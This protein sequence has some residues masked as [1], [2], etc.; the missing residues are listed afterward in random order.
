MRL[1]KNRVICSYTLDS[2]IKAAFPHCNK[3][4]GMTSHF[5]SCNVSYLSPD[6]FDTAIVDFIA[7]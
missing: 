4:N 5:K 3:E 6:I 7:T 1:A 2:R